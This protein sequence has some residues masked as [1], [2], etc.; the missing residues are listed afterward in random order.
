MI[1]NYNLERKYF[2]KLGLQIYSD[3]PGDITLHSCPFCNEGNSLGKKHRFHWKFDTDSGQQSYVNCFNC[4]FAMD[5][6]FFIH[7]I[8]G[9]NEFKSLMKEYKILNEN[10]T[11]FFEK[12]VLEE[13]FILTPQTISVGGME[14][15]ESSQIAYKYLLDRKLEMYKDFFKTDSF[16]NVVIPLLNKQKKLY[17]YQTRIV[18]NKEFWFTLSEQNKKFRAWNFYNINWDEDVYIFESVEDALSSGLENVIAVM[19]KYIT[20]FIMEKL[21]KPIICF[22]NDDD[23]FKSMCRHILKHNHCKAL[24]YP[25]DFKQKDM[26]DLLVKENMNREQIKDFILK[27]IHNNNF[28]LRMLAESICRK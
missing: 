15:I 9:E 24:I 20:P 1:R 12:L 17:G 26:N 2:D 23:G 27:N 16:D 8:A 14:N 25:K 4:N 18:H 22:D 11:N 19:G 5:F 6:E 7:K 28:R 10:E 3:K 21:K 13:D